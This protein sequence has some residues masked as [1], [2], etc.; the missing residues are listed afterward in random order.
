MAGTVCSKVIV[1]QEFM[2]L[3]KVC[4][5]C[6]YYSFYHLSERCWQRYWPIVLRNSVVILVSFLS[7]TIFATSH[8]SGSLPC[9]SE[10]E[11]SV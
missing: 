10:V 5:P 1:R 4:K 2:H 8:C 6:S 9:L 3:R 11:K 7:G